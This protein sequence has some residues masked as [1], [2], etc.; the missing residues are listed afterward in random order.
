MKIQQLDCSFLASK[1]VQK[2]ILVAS[3]GEI[4]EQ[5]I[6][7]V[8]KLGDRTVRIHIMLIRLWV[9]KTGVLRIH[10]MHP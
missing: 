1:F 7:L 2:Q 8:S 3:R 6:L 4:T 9:L 10:N 5:H